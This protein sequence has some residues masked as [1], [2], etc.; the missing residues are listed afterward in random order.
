MTEPYLAPPIEATDHA[1]QPF[2]LRALR[3]RQGVV[4]T[5]FRGTW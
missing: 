1:G 2:S 3:G 5:F 4:L